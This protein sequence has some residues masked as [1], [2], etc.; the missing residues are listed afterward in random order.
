MVVLSGVLIKELW[1]RRLEGD[2]KV[3]EDGPSEK[4]SPVWTP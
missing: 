4:V 3:P 1:F 2:P